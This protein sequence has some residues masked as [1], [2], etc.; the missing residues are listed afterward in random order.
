MADKHNLTP[1]N[2]ELLHPQG[3]PMVGYRI[4]NILGEIIQH[5]QDL[6][7]PAKWNR[8]YELGKNKHWRMQSKKNVSLV[9]A[10]LLHTHRTRTVNMLT[11]N[12][13]TFNIRKTGEAEGK[14]DVYDMLL[15]TAEFWWQ[16][17]E[18][19]AVLDHTVNNG[20]TYG[21]TVEKMLFNPDLE[22]GLGEVEAEPVDPFHIG[23]WPVKQDNIQKCEGVF[24]YFPI[25][26]REARRRWPK[27]KAEIKSDQDLLTKLQDTRMEVQA[28]MTGKK[29]VGAYVTSF[30]DTIK[31]VLNLAGGEKD[32]SDE[33]LVCEVWVKDYT[34]VSKEEGKDV[35][36]YSGNIRRVTALNGGELVVDDRNNP[37]I[38]PEL[39]IEQ[40]SQCYLWDQ[41]PFIKAH[42]ITDTGQPWGM[43]D[44]EQ[45]EMLNIEVNKTISQFTLVKDRLSRLKLI[46]PL[47]SG[48]ANS[49]LTNA[50]GIIN[51][52]SSAV[53]ASIRYL[54]P[55]KMDMNLIEAL[56]IYKEFFF[57]V[58]GSFDM[59]QADNGTNV[60][61]YKAIAALL[62]R[63]ATMIRGKLRNYSALIRE[64][65]RMYLSLMQN[66]YSED[67]FISYEIDGEEITSKINGH[68]MIVPGKLSVVSGSTMPVSKVQQREEALALYDKGAIDAE[69]LLKSIE[70]AD[71][72]RVVARMKMGPIGEFLEKLSM[73]GFPPELIEGLQ[74]V[75]EMEMKDFEKALERGEIPMLQELLAPPEG[76]EE[77]G[78]PTEEEQV[79][80]AEV[81]KV[82]AEIAKINADAA[83][84][85]AEVA[86]VERE[87]ALV[88]EKI[89]TEKANQK[90]TLTGIQLD[91]V[92]ITQD[93]AKLMSDLKTQKIQA[94]QSDVK[95]A[96]D[97]TAQDVKSTQDDAKLTS[98]IKAQD[99]DLK[100]RK[101]ETKVFG[102]DK[103]TQGAYREKGMR[104]NNK[105]K[106][107]KK[108]K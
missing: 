87:T 4:F 99:E 92:K 59:E 69:E 45:L 83:K 30:G 41:F 48:V 55:P 24:H 103:A 6:G 22:G 1:D 35:D 44:F 100:I 54:D 17:T 38:N 94:A 89:V 43:S 47:D 16:E 34:R 3:H 79:A 63:A 77:G 28:N 39:P 62:E 50:P 5:K 96:A 98:D 58:S 104:S 78:M 18:Q 13:P 67:R 56:N 20:E 91:K 40:A 84:I 12:N 46:N 85:N 14:E 72:K 32:E 102:K 42:S 66:W 107:P 90:A 37:S 70:W 88:D 82:M 31:H 27:Y 95:L 105:S 76:A 29:G 9:S 36:L 97:I 108:E 57:L 11:D 19:Q 2:G 65:G 86:K 106:T 81:Q 21:L 74:Q 93:Q 8:C 64:R 68:E 49:Q 101:N 51:P 15:H 7:L 10:N 25:T 26:V 52:A 61:A 73:M 53:A 60:I 33:V 71:W 75:A 23:W 80:A